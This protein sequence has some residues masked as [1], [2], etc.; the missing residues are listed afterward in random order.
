[1]TVRSAA[2]A[3]VVKQS[4]A[5]ANEHNRS[6]GNVRRDIDGERISTVPGDGSV[7]PSSCSTTTT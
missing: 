6:N 2:G 3:A 1:L 5:V 7:S 4:M